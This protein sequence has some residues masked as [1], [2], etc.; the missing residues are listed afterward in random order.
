M[1]SSQEI[2]V[3]MN[4]DIIE[5]QSQPNDNQMSEKIDIELGLK[6]KNF[7]KSSKGDLIERYGLSYAFWQI[8][9][10]QIDLNDNSDPYIKL[11]RLGIVMRSLNH[12][13]E[14]IKSKFSKKNQEKIFNKVKEICK[15]TRND[16]SKVFKKAT[17]KNEP[18]NKENGLCRCGSNI[19]FK[20]CCK[21]GLLYDAQIGRLYDLVCKSFIDDGIYD[22]TISINAIFKEGLDLL[23]IKNIVHFG[24]KN[25][26]GDDKKYSSIGCW[27][28]SYG[29]A[30]DLRNSVHSVLGQQL[31]P[32]FFQKGVDDYFMSIGKADEFECIESDEEVLKLEKEYEL[33]VDGKYFEQN[34][35]DKINKIRNMVLEFV[36][37]QPKI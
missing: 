33:V 23:G 24:Y 27:I 37:N 12:I 14:D 4:N 8:E 9:K 17:V 25:Y 31:D 18:K 6:Y 22:C 28:E 3:S 32:M 34:E 30:Y 36:S 11:V 1:A 29:V 16:N 21:A 10:N 15:I 26:T 20:K 19:K 13:M 35:D 7:V 2:T 5:E